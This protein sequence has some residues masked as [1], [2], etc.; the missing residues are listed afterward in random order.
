MDPRVHRRPRRLAA[1]PPFTTSLSCP[2]TGSRPS[3]A[4]TT[5]WIATSAGTGSSGARA[6]S[7]QGAG[8]E[9]AATRS[10]RCSASYD[11]GV[12]DEFIEPTVIAG[13]PR[14]DPAT[15]AAIFFN[16]RPDRA[17]QLSEKLGRARRRPDDD[18]ALPRR[19]PVPGRVPRAVV[20]GTLAE[21][22][23]RT[24]SASSAPPRRRSTR[25][26]RTSSTAAA[27]SRSRARSGCSCRR[28]ATSRP[29]TCKPEM[30]AAEVADRVRARPAGGYG[31]ILVNFA[32][33]DMVGHT[34]VDPGRDQRRRDDRRV[35]R[36]H[37]RGAT[38]RRRRRLLI[39]ADH[40]NGEPMID[41][42]GAARTPRTRRTPCRSSLTEPAS[43]CATAASSPTWR[44][45]YSHSWGSSSP[46][47]T[48]RT[49]LVDV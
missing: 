9:A 2:P 46:P 41:A 7:S 25:T 36:P 45:R 37:H 44:R 10:R 26:S 33:P 6:R 15:D 27:R 43:S 48:G 5:R 42:D 20:E 38:S 23:A 17:R 49:L 8:A 18:D 34:G 28:R 40:G 16:F 11:A 4:G 13:R 35:P 24:A 3:R 19:L 1:T 39:T 22:L 29:T 12:T 31:F 47:M 32:N 21:V 14:L 30:S